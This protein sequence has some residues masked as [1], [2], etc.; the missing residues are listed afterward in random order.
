MQALRTLSRPLHQQWTP[1]AFRI[2]RFFGRFMTL[3]HAK[4]LHSQRLFD[5]DLQKEPILGSS[6]GPVHGLIVGVFLSHYAR[7]EQTRSPFSPFSL[8]TGLCLI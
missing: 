2:E 7:I 4:G 5:N 6:L 1:Q 3:L 8:G